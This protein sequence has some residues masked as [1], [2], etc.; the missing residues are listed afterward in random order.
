M[1][2]ILLLTL[3]LIFGKFST[4]PKDMII[5]GSI[6]VLF[7]GEGVACGMQS[8]VKDFKEVALIINHADT[9]KTTVNENGV[10]TFPKI[11]ESLT[12]EVFFYYYHTN[13]YLNKTVYY[14]PLMSNTILSKN[15]PREEVG[16]PILSNYTITET[17]TT[18]TIFLN[19][20]LYCFINPPSEPAGFKIIDLPVTE[21]PYMEFIFPQQLTVL[22]NTNLDGHIVVSPFFSFKISEN[23]LVPV[24]S[25]FTFHTVN[26]KQKNETCF[27]GVLNTNDIPCELAYLISD[28]HTEMAESSCTINKIILGKNLGFRYLIPRVML[29]VVHD[30][31]IQPQVVKKTE[32]VEPP[33]IL[34]FNVKNATDKFIVCSFGPVSNLYSTYITADESPIKKN[35]TKIIASTKFAMNNPLNYKAKPWISS[36][37]TELFT[38]FTVFYGKKKIKIAVDQDWTLEKDELNYTYTLLVKLL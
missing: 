23:K 36:F 9:L 16:A 27:K 1:K 38:S 12:F 15:V 18:K 21:Q 7:V 6:N 2:N 10:F 34:T 35:E 4:F 20:G 32:D 22:N 17:K 14:V 33:Y 29:K 5:S 31:K 30:E 19:Y 13:E 3:L 24:Y 8:D 37:P 26:L 28:I 11:D 25:G